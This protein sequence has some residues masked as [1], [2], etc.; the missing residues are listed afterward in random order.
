MEEA[1]IANAS[2]GGENAARAGIIAMILSAASAP[3][4]FVERLAPEMKYWDEINASLE[5]LVPV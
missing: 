5:R 2:V 3:S 1:L 4:P